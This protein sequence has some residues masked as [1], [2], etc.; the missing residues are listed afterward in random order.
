[1]HV[2]EALAFGSQLEVT[3]KKADATV[4]EAANK[5]RM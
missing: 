3:V 5:H 2:T 1:M 4:V